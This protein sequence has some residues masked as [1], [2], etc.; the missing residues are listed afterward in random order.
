MKLLTKFCLGI[1]VVSIIALQWPIGFAIGQTVK[2]R[3]LCE[4]V[5]GN[6]TKFKYAAGGVMRGEKAN[7]TFRSVYY[8]DGFKK[9]MLWSLKNCYDKKG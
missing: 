2:E 9:G 6:T 8:V 1:G 3:A 5:A 4:Q 7:G